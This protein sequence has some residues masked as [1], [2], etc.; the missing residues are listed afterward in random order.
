MEKLRRCCRGGEVARAAAARGERVKVGERSPR[1]AISDR[2]CDAADADSSRACVASS[3]C[4][5]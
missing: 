5:L 4:A 3:S 2:I 1:R